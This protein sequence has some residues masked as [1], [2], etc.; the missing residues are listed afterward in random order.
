MNEFS[1]IK[2]S[3]I[4]HQAIDASVKSLY[5]AGGWLQLVPSEGN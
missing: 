3:D 4:Q 2:V 1:E 5:Q